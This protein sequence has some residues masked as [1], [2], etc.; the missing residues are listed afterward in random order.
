MLH[1]FVNRFK[2]FYTLRLAIMT[3]NMKRISVEFRM[4]KGLPIWTGKSISVGEKSLI[5]VRNIGNGAYG[6]VSL[7][8]VNR[9][10]HAY[11][12]FE[13]PDC[14]SSFRELYALSSLSH[15][16]IIPL[17]GFVIDA[18]NV[19]KGYLM[20]CADRSL[21]DLIHLLPPP[22][23][24]SN[25]I[26]SLLDNIGREIVG[27]M[28][29][30]HQNSFLH[31]DIKPHNVLLISGRACLAD[32]GL[33]TIIPDGPCLNT[34][35]VHTAL[36]RAPELFHLSTE[37][38]KYG[39]EADVY[40]MGIT[41]I[42]MYTGEY[43][44]SQTGLLIRHAENSDYPYQMVGSIHKS[45]DHC[46]NVP[47]R[48]LRLMTSTVI[49]TRPGAMEISLKWYSV[50][51]PTEFK[52]LTSKAINSSKKGIHRRLSEHPTKFISKCHG[53]R[54]EIARES[55]LISCLKKKKPKVDLS[56]IAEIACQLV[57]FDGISPSKH[58]WKA[59]HSICKASII[60]NQSKTILF[61]SELEKFV[62]RNCRRHN[63]FI[64]K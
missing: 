12:Q 47:T 15:P 14:Q 43:W 53:S 64:T 10:H 28:A 3:L 16:S 52:M 29:Y 40:A 59:M 18:E 24:R 35:E 9:K 20:P 54:I 36:Y 33:A 61:K 49:D 5:K 17:S 27:G 55:Y 2:I 23:N 58:T 57:T 46:K 50:I 34:G 48:L 56:S 37:R 62:H 32:F 60:K 7:V 39:P 22:T 8:I 41:L 44:M 31:R 13:E 21:M 11:K 45:L 51:K 1:E 6:S 63:R 30:L 42:H 26:T 19:I 4:E 25:Q 38:T